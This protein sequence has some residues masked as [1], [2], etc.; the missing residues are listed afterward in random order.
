MKRIFYILL[1]V[2]VLISIFTSIF[3]GSEVL[4]NS[5]L[6][7]YLLGFFVVIT[8]ALN[9]TKPKKL[10][11]RWCGREYSDSFMADIYYCSPK[12]EKESKK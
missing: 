11:C 2:F 4:M 8:M 1:G 6:F 9:P 5:N 12:C 3:F 7:L 10:G